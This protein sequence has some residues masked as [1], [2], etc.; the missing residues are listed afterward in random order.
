MG[1]S[2]K[3]IAK[4]VSL[5]R[6]LVSECIFKLVCFCESSRNLGYISRKKYLLKKSLIRLVLVWLIF[7]SFNYN[8]TDTAAEVYLEPLQTYILELFSKNS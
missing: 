7:M 4:T 2:V 1:F 3:Y 6:F 5:K 8:E